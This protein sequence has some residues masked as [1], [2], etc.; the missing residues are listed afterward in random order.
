MARMARIVL[1]GVAYHVTHRGNQRRADS[2]TRAVGMVHQRHAR[3]HMRP[4]AGRPESRCWR[5]NVLSAAIN[6]IR[7]AAGRLDGRTGS[8]SRTQATPR[9]WSAC[10]RRRT[11]AAPAATRHLLNRS[12]PNSATP[13][14]PAAAA[15]NPNT[16]RR[17]KTSVSCFDKY[18][19][20]N[21][22]DIHGY[23]PIEVTPRF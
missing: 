15:A 7:S 12:R 6:P 4:V 9:R 1:P 22:P 3:P 14:E 18:I 23:H 2:P 16:S 17:I 8:R 21:V 11:P 19:W 13:P 20:S 5:P 10:D